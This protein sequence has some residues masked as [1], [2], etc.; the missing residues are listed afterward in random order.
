MTE[1]FTQQDAELATVGLTTVQGGPIT[2]FVGTASAHMGTNAC[3]CESSNL[4]S[5][6]TEHVS[7]DIRTDV[8]PITVPE[9]KQRIAPL[10]NSYTPL[11]VHNKAHAIA[12]IVPSN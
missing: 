5:H 9:Q 3:A 7:C 4:L 12:Q 6:C 2:S 10:R 11:H 1:G 8:G